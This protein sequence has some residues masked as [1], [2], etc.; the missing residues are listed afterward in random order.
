MNCPEISPF[1]HEFRASISAF[2]ENEIDAL[3]DSDF[4]NWYKYQINSRGIVDP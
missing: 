3:V 4:V 1:Y 2:L